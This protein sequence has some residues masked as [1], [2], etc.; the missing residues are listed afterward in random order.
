[1]LLR[2]SV[3]IYG[4]EGDGKADLMNTMFGVFAIIYAGFGLLGT[5]YGLAN[6]KTYI[7]YLFPTVMFA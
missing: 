5:V 2:G 7:K 6:D 4:I 3:S 1:M